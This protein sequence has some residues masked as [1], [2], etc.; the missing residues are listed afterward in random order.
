MIDVKREPKTPFFG[1][2][3]LICLMTLFVIPVIGYEL[4]TSA[5][6]NSSDAKGQPFGGLILVMAGLVGVV[7]VL[8]IAA[9]GSAFAGGI[10]LARGESRR[11]AGWLG[12]LGGGSM[13]VAVAGMALYIYWAS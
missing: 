6:D 12:L 3:S 11:W 10:A 9:F 1:I 2:V 13:F 5:L 8:G 4:T 7:I